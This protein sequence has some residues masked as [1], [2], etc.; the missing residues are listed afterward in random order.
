MNFH[1]IDF[2]G[3]VLAAAALLWLGLL[4]FTAPSLAV[5]RHR[6]PALAAAFLILLLMWGLSAQLQHGM[7]AGVAYHMLGGAL[8][9]LMVGAGAAFWVLNVL[10]LLFGLWL[11]PAAD[12]TAIPLNVLLMAV[13][14]IAVAQAVLYWARRYLPRHLFVFIFVNGFLAAGLSLLVTALLMVLVWQWAGVYPR[15]VLWGSVWPV[16]FLLT[17]AEAFLSGLLTAIFVALAPQLLA[18]YDDEHY[19]PPARPQ[20]LK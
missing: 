8:L 6:L 18:A 2:P 20:I 1:S 16:Y 17:W 15:D 19:L 5:Q 10:M 3:W 12:W 11:L 13:P 14:A 4:V 9:T 7:A